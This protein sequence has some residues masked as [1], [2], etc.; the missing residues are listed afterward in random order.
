MRE[1]KRWTNQSEAALQ[2]ALDSAAWDMF[3]SSAG[4]DVEEFM[5]AVVGFTDKV[6]D[7]T[8]FRRNI[9]TCPNQ[10]PEWINLQYPWGTRNSIRLLRC[11]EGD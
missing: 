2:V 5:E 1:V 3:R 6:V 7:E 9:W 4:G 8:T 10:K 11:C